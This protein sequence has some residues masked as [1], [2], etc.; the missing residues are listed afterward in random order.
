MAGWEQLGYVPD[1]EEE[2]EELSDY[3]DSQKRTCQ[4]VLLTLKHGLEQTDD[5]ED[6]AHKSDQEPGDAVRLKL[7]HTRDKE[8]QT[9]NV[10]GKAPSG[11]IW[12]FPSSSQDTDELQDDH[13]DIQSTLRELS[14][15]VAQSNVQTFRQGEISVG[16]RPS[17]SPVT[18]PPLSPTDHSTTASQ[19]PRTDRK[20]DSPT[21]DI[22]EEQVRD[23]PSQQ[24]QQ[25]ASSYRDND[26]AQ[27]SRPLRHRNPIQLHPYAIEG[28]RYRQICKH[29]GV[30][31]LRIVQ[32]ESQAT[33]LL[34]DSQAG[35]SLAN[36]ST[37]NELPDAPNVQSSPSAT[38]PLNASSSGFAS[39]FESFDADEGDLPDLEFIL[40]RLPP[41]AVSNGHK[42]R[43]VVRSVGPKSQKENRR[44]ERFNSKQLRTPGTADAATVFDIPPSPPQSQ[45]PDPAWASRPHS[46]GFRIP[47]GVSPIAL[48]TPIR[49]SESGQPPTLAPRTSQSDGHSS[50]SESSESDSES[51]R[52]PS[53]DGKHRQLHGIQRKIKGVLPASWLKLDLRTQTKKINLQTRPHENS[54]PRKDISHQR[55]VARPVPPRERAREL[56]KGPIQT[57][58]SSS[59]NHSDNEHV[60]ISALQGS[61]PTSPEQPAIVAD[62][63]D[64]DLLRPG[65]SWGEVYE[66][67]RVDAMLPSKPRQKGHGRE[68][69]ASSSKRRQTRLTDLQVL[70]EHAG[71]QPM[72]RRER[73]P[74][75]TNKR[76]IAEGLDKPAKAK[77][78]PP[79]LSI[80]D[81][82]S[83][84]VSSNGLAP[85][86]IRLAQRISRSRKDRGKCN[87][88]RKYLRLMTEPETEEVNAHLRSWRQGTLEPRAPQAPRVTARK[89][90]RSPLKPCTG[91]ERI[92]P[93]RISRLDQASD[94]V[95][96]SAAKTRSTGHKTKSLKSRSIQSSLD[97][98][99]RLATQDRQ[100][101][102]PQPS[103]RSKA[104]MG[105]DKHP[106]RL[107]RT[108][109]L[110]SSLKESGSARP[111]TL[112]SLQV[113]IDRNHPRSNFHRRLAGPNHP[114]T[115]FNPLLAKFLDRPGVISDTNCVP[116]QL[117]ASRTAVAEPDPVKPRKARK[118][119]P[120]RLEI[121]SSIS[122]GADLSSGL[123]RNAGSQPLPLEA[124]ARKQPALID[125]RPTGSTYTT[126]FDIAS[127]PVGTCFCGRTFVGSGDFARS[128]ITSD[129]HHVRG[130]SFFEHGHATFQWGPWDDHVSTELGM[131]VD[132]A[133][134][135]FQQ[136]LD[137]RHR[138][139]DSTIG[140]TIELLKRIIG[141][142]STN[143]SFH[144]MIDRTALLQSCKSLPL[145]LSETLTARYDERTTPMTQK[146][147][148][149][150]TEA[151][152]LCTVFASQLLQI[153][154][155]PVVSQTLRFELDSILQ[156]IAAKALSFALHDDFSTFTQRTRSLIQ[157]SST[158]VT[159]D[160]SHASSELLV[161]ACHVLS[162]DNSVT[163]LWQVLHHTLL[164][165]SLGSSN[166]VRTLETLWERLF[167]VLPFLEFDRHGVLEVG[168][169]LRKA[170]DNWTFV[171]RLLEPVFE[172]YKSKT[173]SQPPNIN[174]YCRA[175][176]GRC[177]QLINVW[178]WHRCESI[179]G[180]LFDFFAQRNLSHLPNEESHGSPRFLS[181]L[182][183]KRSLQLAHEDRC[184]HILLKVMAS[185][186]QHMQKIY[187][188]KKIRDIVWRLMPNHGRLL[189]KDQAIQQTDLDALRNHH[190]LL[191]TLYW[192][193]PQSYRPRPA[194]IQDLVDVENSHK[195]ACRINIRAWSNLMTFQ[196]SASEPLASLEPFINWY[197]DLLRQILQ[198]HH[199]ARTELEE[200]ARSAQSTEGLL[201]STSLL[202][203]TIA[204]NQRQVE[205][206]LSDVLL[207]MKNAISIA[208]DL[209]AARMLLPSD[210]SSVFAL[211]EAR[212]SR[213]NKVVVD[214]LEILITFA[215]KALPH[216][217]AVASNDGDDSQDYGD[218]SAFDAE[219]IPNSAISAIAEHLE[220]QFQ[221]PLRQLLSN[222]LGAD[223]PPEDALLA[224]VIDAWL[225]VGRVLTHGGIKVWADYIE[226]Y[227]QDSWASLRETEQTHRFSA[228]Y[229]AALVEID[230]EVFE[231][232]R[233]TLLQAWA[234]SLVERE[235][236]L[237]YQHRLTNSLLNAHL[238]DPVL[239]N[240]PCWAVDGRFQIT[241]SAFSERRLSLISNMLSNMR[242]L[243]EQHPI[244]N[245]P[246]ATNPKSSCK[247]I[248]R[249]MMNTM[250][251]NYHLMGQGS[252]TGGAYVNFVHRVI[253]LLQ[254]HTLSISP[255]DR[256]FT[257]SSSFPL[258]ATDPQY[259]VGQL[260]NYGMR[261]QDHRTPKQLSVFIQSVSERA[262]VDGQQGHL[263]D[264]L[265]S[266]MIGNVGQDALPGSDLRSFLVTTIFPA[267]IDAALS[268]S[269]GWVMS[270]PILQTLR[271]VL[272]SIM[273][274]V[275]GFDEVRV[276]S[277]NTMILAVLGDFLISSNH[278]LDYPSIM[279]QPKT[280]KT[281]A[282]FFATITA[283]LPALDYLCRVTG[284]C[285]GGRSMMKFF[286]SFAL[287]VAQSLLGHTDI[288]SPDA[289]GLDEIMIGIQNSDVRAFAKQELRETLNKNWICHEEHYYVNRGL[290]RREVVVDIGLFEEEKLAII[291]ELELFFN[292]LDRTEMLRFGID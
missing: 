156:D 193:S 260:K 237:K 55:G 30:R 38:T 230:R 14:T 135:R 2:E 43:K 219:V 149:I 50:M 221:P 78:Q 15:R 159:L 263:I 27:R 171:K 250:K 110:L 268:T 21:S 81:V 267:Y 220:D 249:V 61:I 288:E 144:D 158:C 225:A 243:V 275:N 277:I 58:D 84:S 130:S 26:T 16:E 279:E 291:K 73:R 102:Y 241:P 112:E 146:L 34:D 176:F 276:A 71:A 155:H 244:G 85:S 126:S 292:A 272:S 210:L 227:G 269:C 40:R 28:E 278:V 200:Q 23:L 261:L 150:R 271:R 163:T 187:S 185:G 203:S 246:E 33:S 59:E 131:L 125:L 209:E 11:T 222:C 45:S 274:D 77:F 31:P 191:C 184:F 5:A 113:H 118:R 120:R 42:R 205:A 67:N 289:S 99:V 161:I 166:N 240:P 90:T 114:T 224:K 172:A 17:S 72:R 229:F 111:A 253:E 133:C 46:K 68:Q 140:D 231:E 287:F 22:T 280:L 157:C 218:W 123:D 6:A 198:Q 74:R 228:Y 97:N 4:S 165:T 216:H 202:E 141:Y 232:H 255:V 245:G 285:R 223:T 95:V 270:L 76:S 213:T 106:K 92:T 234:G 7:Q 194:V 108:G 138:A 242:K 51:S 247:E 259:V 167:A 143:L 212:S 169:R 63:D 119:R 124:I 122:P 24:Q 257:D 103:D 75:G 88:N 204:Q 129:L 182:D 181:N 87:L 265:I 12:D 32:G 117:Y 1:S 207:S 121:P 284:S 251:S 3:N 160:E 175:L 239:A 62:S 105:E 25:D 147:K 170:T 39:V 107:S 145:R 139:F 57:L 173:H 53:E 197:Q 86:F 266:V 206:I 35:E 115:S 44:G 82:F 290:M 188:G 179:I 168:R 101:A 18:L 190:D 69:R 37:Q 283:V 142:M 148:G 54:S 196:L 154:N 47:R 189:P 215:N 264:Q 49:S 178:G 208:P 91:N 41:D 192:A 199:N 186:V 152:S 236:L 9:R 19:Q 94:S 217:P 52:N 254:Q 66:D 56:S 235:M 177:L 174:A 137:Q 151:L 214:A 282:S 48:P 273:A 180:T 116:E 164:S 233:Q 256:F 8:D 104:K 96:Q 127:L 153:S 201:V 262:A 134:Q 226:G 100:Q 258:P 93:D 70:R 132:E 36:T 195:E 10:N 162:T 60:G 98:I 89:H 136:P 286:K 109:H 128:F 183:R 20:D 64:R 79:D 80:L 83:L 238:D 13:Y 281:I 65:D 248:L 29:S 252:D 211:F